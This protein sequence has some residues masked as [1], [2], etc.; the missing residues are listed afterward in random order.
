MSRISNLTP[1][2]RELLAL[3]RRDRKAASQ[4]MGQLSVEAQVALMSEAPLNRRADLLDLSPT[5]ETLIPALPEAELCFTIKQV[6]IADASWILDHASEQQIATC[7]DLDAWQG[8]V[9]DCEAL[10][11]WLDALADASPE[12]FLKGIR[13]LDAE[14]VVIFLKNRISVVQKPPQDDEDWEPPTGSQTLDGQFYF[15][16][17]RPDD[18][19]A[20]VLKMLHSL[21][22]NEYWTYFRMLQGVSWELDAENEEWALRWRTARLQDL[23]FPSWDESMRIYRYVKPERLGRLNLDERPPAVGEWHLPVWIPDLP[24]LADDR[25]AIFD[26]IAKLE[27]EERRS[28]FYAFVAL[29]NKVAVADRMELSDAEST[30]KAIEKTARFASLGLEFVAAEN[31]TDVTEVVRSSTLERLFN[32]GANLEP[33][34]ARPPR[35]PEEPEDDPDPTL[36]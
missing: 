11:Q 12:A 15:S 27:N 29:A 13:S 3:A 35:P 20:S 32:V 34:A 1:Q 30:P 10:D 4:A 5:P 16:L 23:G 28:A 21:F 7:V 9:P 26:A 24:Q 36:N 17:V 25:F 18:D 31:G 6:G 14:V 2:L 22:N 19:G 8:T 33:A